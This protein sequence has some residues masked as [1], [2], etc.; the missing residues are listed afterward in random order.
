MAWI[1]SPTIIFFLFIVAVQTFM[2]YNGGATS[3]SIDDIQS[4]GNWHP[5]ALGALGAMDKVG[6]TMAS[7]FWGYALQI[8]PA[9]TLLVGGLF[10]NSLSIL[11]FGTLTQHWTMYAAKLL[12]GFTEGLQ[13]VWAPL[14]ISRW[15]EQSRLALWMNIS[16]GVVAGV[17]SGIGIIIAGFSTANG[18]T[19]CFAFKVEAAVLVTLW[20]LMLPV[21]R[22]NLSIKVDICRESSIALLSR[23]DSSA[24]FLKNGASFQDC[25]PSWTE[26]QGRK[27]LQIKESIK[28][29]GTFRKATFSTAIQSQGQQMWDN[30]VFLWAAL[31]LCSVNFVTSGMQFTWIR[32][33]Q[34]LWGMSKNR[35]VTSFLLAI[36]TGSAAGIFFGSRVDCPPSAEGRAHVAAWC[37]RAHLLSLLG[38]LVAAAGL[39]WRLSG[40]MSYL[41]QHEV[42]SLVITWLGMV[43]VF[44]GL[45]STPGLLQILCV[46]SFEDEQ[47]QSLSTGIYQLLVN[48]LGLA[49]GP[50]LP[51]VVMG[52]TVTAFPWL[53]EGYGVKDPPWALFAGFMCLLMGT[54]AGV[55][56]TSLTLR[57]A[58]EDASELQEQC[59]LLG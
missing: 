27:L 53:A 13:W 4:V 48:F 16:G 6:M 32:T 59:Q 12:I 58:R 55:A 8:W 2:A 7:A 38:A 17:G 36:A 50:F 20:M 25:E 33:F 11:L 1:P 18:F 14:W 39:F 9:K 3:G 30:R 40:W 34:S 51:Q 23:G 42:P 28:G 10:V 15:A 24:D 26:S 37:R 54:A 35:A 31:S 47:T 49:M 45:N 21:N 43:V 5:A 46:K 29:K 22:Q 56:L 57:G 41:D 19:Y 52:A 44:G